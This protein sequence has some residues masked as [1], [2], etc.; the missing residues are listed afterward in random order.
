MNYGVVVV[1]PQSK[2]VKNIGDYIQKIA[3]TQY[4][5]NTI[6]YIDRED[7]YKFESTKEIKTIINGV[8]LWNP[9]HWPP[10]D[11]INP[12]FIS[13]HIFPFAEEKLFTNANIEYW[14]KYA[15]IGCRDLG[16]L[17][18][19]K[20]HNIPAYF[21]ACATLTLGDKYIFKGIRHGIYFVDPYIPL[22]LFKDGASLKKINITEI[23]STFTFYL[24][25]RKVIKLLAKK[26][27]FS[28]YGPNWGHSHY[29]GL[30][31]MFMKHYHAMQFYKLYSQKFSKELLLN[32]QYITH[33]YRLKQERKENDQDLC[34]VAENLI[35]TYAHAKMVITSRIHA[36]LP[37]LGI[38]TP[39]IF[40]LNSDMESD[41]FK[42]NSPGRFGGIID[43][44]RIMRIDN[45]HITSKDEV[46]SQFNKIGINTSFKNKDNYKLYSKSLKEKIKEF[47]SKNN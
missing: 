31:L 21:S 24:N 4:L 3:I 14:K 45:Y 43:F 7:L 13:I 36:A 22:P 11:N 16:T 34:N 38:E 23:P 27:F 20:K 46:L 32:A 33:M 18:M 10:S 30:K 35:K 25:N 5:N 42:F 29:R 26:D 15:P 41:S 28:L 19:F 2:K 8:Y 47:I 1:R 37:C 17:E 39:V 6:Y 44:F 40:I 9:N 12:L